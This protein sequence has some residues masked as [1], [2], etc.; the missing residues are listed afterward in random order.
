[1]YSAKNLKF[2]D[3]LHSN[4]IKLKSS[5]SG[6]IFSKTEC[7]KCVKHIINV[8]KIQWNVLPTLTWL[9]IQIA[10]GQ[11]Q[12]IGWSQKYSPKKVFLS[13]HFGTWCNKS[14]KM[15]RQDVTCL[16]A[17]T[18]TQTMHSALGWLS[19]V[20]TRADHLFQVAVQLLAYIT[21][22]LAVELKTVKDL[23]SFNSDCWVFAASFNPLL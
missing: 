20:H 10:E 19:H 16:S 17:T 1:M 21:L 23:N 2:R 3:L 8:Q 7:S 22:I 12:D 5:F 14:R 15:W 18:L 13:C 4:F 6:H 9:I 11:N